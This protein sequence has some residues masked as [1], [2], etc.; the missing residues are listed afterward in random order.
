MLWTPRSTAQLRN[1]IEIVFRTSTHSSGLILWTGSNLHDRA[2]P[3]PPSDSNPQRK[4]YLGLFIA[5]GFLE[6]RLDLDLSKA[7]E[8]PVIIRSKVCRENWIASAG[9][10][11]HSLS[12]LD[13]SVRFAGEGK[14]QSMASDSDSTKGKVR[15]DAS[16]WTG[17]FKN[18]SSSRQQRPC[19]EWALLD[20][21]VEFSFK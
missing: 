3:L 15:S 16:G 7:D 2:T 5:D 8:Q 11:Q 17:T 19:Y 13:F 20:W 14:W 9:S 10:V 21:Y 1:R 12:L 18:S 6:L 4:G